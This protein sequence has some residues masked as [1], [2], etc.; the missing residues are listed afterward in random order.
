MLLLELFNVQ[1][2]NLTPEQFDYQP[3][4]RDEADLTQAYLVRLGLAKPR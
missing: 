4:E 2:S 1:R 3:S